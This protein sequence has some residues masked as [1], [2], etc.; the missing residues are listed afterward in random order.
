MSI[1]HRNRIKEIERID[2]ELATLGGQYERIGV[3]IADLKATRS[4]AVAAF[5][6]E[7]VSDL[8]FSRVSVP[9]LIDCLTRLNDDR[10]AGDDSAA[11]ED[12]VN[13]KRGD[14]KVHVK[15]SSNAS[16][17]NRAILEASGLGWN[18]R[19]AG[20]TGSVGSA[21]LAKLHLVFKNRVT[22][23]PQLEVGEPPTT[24]HESAPRHVYVDEAQAAVQDQ[25]DAPET[26]RDEGEQADQSPVRPV[27]T[28]FRGL[29]VRRLPVSLPEPE[30]PA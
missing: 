10:H 19:A 13:R 26:R 29:P 15:L 21:E 3:R 14:F 18:G 24:S 6:T 11:T 8:D 5:A 17:K 27:M 9:E 16:V 22:P 7:L 20:W 2:S 28:P 4:K 23:G 30:S 12:D 25:P 1:L